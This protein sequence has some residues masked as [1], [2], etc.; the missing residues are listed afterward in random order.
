VTA[1]IAQSI[2]SNG[3]LVAVV[4]LS[5][6]RVTVAKRLTTRLRV[7]PYCLGNGIAAFCLVILHN[8]AGWIGFAALL[9][10]VALLHTLLSYSA[11]RVATHELERAAYQEE[12]SELFQ[13]WLTRSVST[14]T[15]P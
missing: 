8:A 15:L 1:G 11:H 9:V 13:R 10:V 4:R 14:R 6:P 12:V 3:L 7:L 5:D 2:V